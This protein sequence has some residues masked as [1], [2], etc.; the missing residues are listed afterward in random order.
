[1]DVI[2]F[3]DD[4]KF[5]KY[6]EIM[7]TG[8]FQSVEVITNTADIDE[9]TGYINK[10][11]SPALF[12]LDI[13]IGKESLGFDVACHIMERRVK[14]IIVFMTDYP[15]KI[16]FNSDHKVNAY[17]IILKR[18]PCFEEE[19]KFTIESALRDIFIDKCF[20]YQD[21][22]TNLSIDIEGIIYIETVKGKKRVCIYHE[23]G[24]YMLNIR[25]NNLLP[26]L[27]TGFFRCHD[28]YIVNLNKI[29]KINHKERKITMKNGG[30]C[31]YSY[32]KRNEF[33]NCVKEG[34]Y[35]I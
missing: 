10:M 20:V 34:K 27:G 1:M 17:N 4:K 14:N 26:Q 21:R 30:T 13:I 16:L 18:S 23:N 12:F 11:K 31:Y 24:V 35:E 33:L 25:M 9:L 5:S 6:L 32:L 8:S 28:S 15:N 22:F 2:I 19:I 3:D 7:I 29:A